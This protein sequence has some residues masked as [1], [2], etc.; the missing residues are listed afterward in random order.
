MKRLIIATL[1]A[2][3]YSIGCGTSDSTDIDQQLLAEYRQAIPSMSQL[4]APTVRGST[5][6]AAGDPAMI[7]THSYPLVEGING[8]VAEL[9]GTLEAVVALPPTVFNSD[10]Q[11]FFWGPFANEEGV[12]F[13]GV[14]IRDVGDSEDFR[15]HYAFLRGIDNDVANLGPG[16]LGRRHPAG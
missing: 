15:Y 10:T 1:L 13:V 2:S 4:E 9:I 11:E 7:P 5:A 3:T 8:G 12:G 14:Y 6:T 16:G